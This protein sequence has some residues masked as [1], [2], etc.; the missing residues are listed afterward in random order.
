MAV[1][2]NIETY[3]I[4]N[5]ELAAYPTS[6]IV[7]DNLVSK[8][9][10]TMTAKFVDIPIALKQKVQ[11][12]FEYIEKEKC[13]TIYNYVRNKIVNQHTRIFT[14]N[15]KGP[16]GWRSGEFYLGTPITFTSAASKNN[17]DITVWKLELHFIEIQGDLLNSPISTGG[18]T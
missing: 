16:T 9:Y 8:S 15:Y 1:I 17:G 11:W 13:E 14:I 3:T 18:A 4:D 12:V 6:C 10:N 2:S 5:I 7:S